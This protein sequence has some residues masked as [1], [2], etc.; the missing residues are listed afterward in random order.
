MV[1]LDDGILDHSN[2]VPRLEDGGDS[3]NEPSLRKGSP[4]VWDWSSS[5]ESRNAKSGGSG[6]RE[7]GWCLAEAADLDADQLCS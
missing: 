6:S 5:V 2:E 4:A 3:L 1:S 7:A